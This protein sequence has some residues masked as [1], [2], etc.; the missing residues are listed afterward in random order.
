MFQ[1]IRKE[2]QQ[3]ELEMK[4]AASSAVTQS[5]SSETSSSNRTDQGPPAL[6]RNQGF[7]A[8]ALTN[9]FVIIGFAAFAFTVK[10]VLRNV[11]D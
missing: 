7:L 4:Q 8:S 11:V 6:P 3:R 9:I 2:I 1:D 10:Y 5:S